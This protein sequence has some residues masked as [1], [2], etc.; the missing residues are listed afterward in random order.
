MTSV[1]LCVGLA[2]GS[3]LAFALIDIGSSLCIYIPVWRIRMIMTTIAQRWV[4]ILIVLTWGT[5]IAMSCVFIS[6]RTR[7]SLY[8]WHVA[9]K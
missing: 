9:P 4:L 1:H 6:S 5:I 8:S 3:V 7:T 2:C